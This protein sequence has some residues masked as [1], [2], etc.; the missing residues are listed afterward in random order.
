VAEAD[1]RECRE[2][3]AVPAIRKELREE[4]GKG[5]MDRIQIQDINAAMLKISVHPLSLDISPAPFE[6]NVSAISLPM[7]MFMLTL[8]LMYCGSATLGN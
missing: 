1:H 4:E 6:L 2:W 3:Y 5:G 7:L 8:V